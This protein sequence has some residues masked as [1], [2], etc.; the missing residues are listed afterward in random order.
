MNARRQPPYNKTQTPAEHCTN[1]SCLL[2]RLL[3]SYWSADQAST[4]GR[5]SDAELG[6]TA[7]LVGD[8]PTFP[9]ALQAALRQAELQPAIYAAVQPQH[10]GWSIRDI[11]RSIRNAHAKHHAIIQPLRTQAGVALPE[12]ARVTMS[13]CLDASGAA[14]DQR[15][16]HR[17]DCSHVVVL[18]DMFSEAERCQVLDWLTAPG[19]DHSQ[20]P[21]EARWE[22]SCV[23]RE[24]DSVTWGV[25]PEVLAALQHEP[26][27][28]L[29]AIQSRL[30]DLYP[31]F[32][33]CYMPAAAMQDEDEV[34]GGL[35]PFVGNAV[36]HGEEYSWHID[37]DPAQVDVESPWARHF[38]LYYNRE[39]GKPLFVSMLM[40]LDADWPEHFNAETM[41]LDPDT[42]AGVFVRPRAGR[43]VL[44]DQDVPHRISAPSLAAGRARYSLVW[45]LVFVPKVASLF[46]EQ[47]P[48]LSLRHRGASLQPFGSATG[49]PASL[50]LRSAA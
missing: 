46:E 48:T 35:S 6:R 1:L 4:S 19:W 17:D 21:P 47:T 27:P 2:L 13:I 10:L 36:L 33:I 24:G 5:A 18:D 9:H 11:L 45:K 39:A 15:S 14:L 30:A 49:P 16:E 22:R 12:A 28:S 7:L 40:Y 41:F 23:D 8:S 29:V 38:G 37:A 32:H 31:H 43:L 44:M 34:E 26:P 3:Q 42:D 20:G 50:K 25:R